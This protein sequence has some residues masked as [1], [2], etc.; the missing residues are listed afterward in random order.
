MKFKVLMSVASL[1]MLALAGCASSPDSKSSSTAP[2]KASKELTAQAIVARHRNATYGE[3]KTRKHSATTSKGILSIEQFGID[4]PLVIYAAAPNSSSTRIEVM[5]M[6][7]NNGCHK[8][9]C[10]AQQPGAGTTV[11]S[12]AAAE[13]QAQQA[14]YNQFDNWHR[15]YASLEIVPNA[16]S[17]NH[18]IK[19]V[20]KNGDTDLYEFSKETGLIVSAVLQA[21]TPQGKTEVGMQFKNYK[22]FDGEMIATEINQVTPQATIKI[23]LNE[24]S[25]APIAEDMFA[26]PN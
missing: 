8:D 10:W 1:A 16:D 12:G 23:V 13:F 24:V 7:L 17:P 18:K 14:D 15:Y 22:N 25:F 4:A 2:A 19:A 20:R 26:K 6:T 9:V 3:A 21:E 5:G 11:L